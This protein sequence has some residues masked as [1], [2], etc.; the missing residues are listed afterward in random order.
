MDLLHTTGITPGIK[1]DCGLESRVGDTKGKYWCN[2]GLNDIY[3][4][5]VAHYAGGAHF[6][7][8][9]TVVRID[10]TNNPPRLLRH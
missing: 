9:H 2:S 5:Y 8:C 7:K 1:V 6:A 4:N 3:D 10:V